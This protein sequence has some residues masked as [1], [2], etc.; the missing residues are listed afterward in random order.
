[1][2]DSI[3]RDEV[4]KDALWHVRS[5]PADGRIGVDLLRRAIRLL[6]NIIRQDNLKLT[7]TNRALW[8]LDYASLF[9]VAKQMVY[10]VADGL[11]PAAEDINTIKFRD[12]GGAD[13]EVS[14]APRAF[15]DSIGNK[16]E[17]GD[18]TVVYLKMGRIPPDNSWFIHPQPSTVTAPSE[19]LGNDSKN[20]QCLLK[21]T[22]VAENAPGE[23][24][25]NR[26]FWQQGGKAATASWANKTAYTTGE[27]LVYS[28]KRPLTDFK[29]AY[30][31]P[32]MPL[33][34]ENYLTYKLALSLSAGKDVGQQTIGVLVG[35]LKEAEQAIFPSRRANTTTFHNKNLYY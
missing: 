7:G 16:V 13:N 10:T 27:Q 15:W 3:K 1:M 32:D 35:L 23:G 14:L 31:N 28:F 9:L 8:A 30:A 26:Q 29:D 12:S 34:W 21:H 6:N 4:I 25:N 24:P 2:A 22:S 18:T 20:Y 19:V 11:S 17:P 33:G 5:L